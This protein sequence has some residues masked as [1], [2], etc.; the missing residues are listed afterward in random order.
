M[1]ERD[2]ELQ[3]LIDESAIRNLLAHYPRGLDRHDT[4]TL[5]SIYHHDGI[6]DHGVFN[7]SAQEY[8]DWMAGRN[9]E[10]THWM[11]NNTTQVIEVDGD[12][13][14]SETY[15]LAF[16]RIPEPEPDGRRKEYLTRVRYLD[17]LEKRD[18]EW[19]I[20]HRKVVYAPNGYL[21]V[22]DI[23]PTPDS[24]IEAGVGVDEVYRW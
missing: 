13:A 10:G 24:F 19:K 8:V 17:R 15:C 3:R 23:P 1:A 12:V 16:K 14:F 20:A 2:P 6:E 4:E 9:V 7:G 5:A 22:D 18:G 11:H 21:Y